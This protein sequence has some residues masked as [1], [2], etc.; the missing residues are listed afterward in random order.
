MK[1]HTK[2]IISLMTVLL[3]VMMLVQSIQYFS[4]MKLIDGLSRSE[5]NMLHR[6]EEQKALSLFLTV[7]RAVEGS[8]IRGEMEKFTHLVQSLS[9]IEGLKAFS[10][11]DA[12]GVMTHSSDPKLIGR[13]LPKDLTDRLYSQSERYQRE[14]D[15]S[16]EIFQPYRVMADCIRCHTT[17]KKDQIG[18]ITHFAFSKEN[19]IQAQ[20]DTVAAMAL[21]QDRFLRT[22]VLAVL[23]LI[24]F[25]A[26]GMY[27]TVRRFVAR[28]LGRVV[29]M[30]RDI[31]QGEGDLTARLELNS[32]DEIGE[33]AGWFNTFVEKL[34][35]VIRQIAEN[36]DALGRA[37]STMS[38]VAGIMARDSGTLSE[39][40]GNL[41]SIAGQ[42][43]HDMGD[44]A[45]SLETLNANIKSIVGAIEETTASVGAISRNAGQS[46][47]IAG[48]AAQ[49]AEQTGQTV[50]KLRTS[51][52]A[53][54]KVIE[55]IVDIAEQTKLLALN[56]TIEAARAGEAGKGFAVVA[57]E[58]KDLAG[59]TSLSTKD[60]RDKVEEIQAISVET[61]ESIDQILKVIGRVNDMAGSIAAAVEQQSS[62]TREIKQSVSQAA[63]AGEEVSISTARAAALCRNMS[64]SIDEV[65]QSSGSTFREAGQVRQASQELAGLAETLRGLLS[66]FRY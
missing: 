12:S 3:V 18:G 37:A 54:G 34:Q 33:L 20:K 22:S 9:D 15:H 63:T 38:D 51:A 39:Q 27:L 4:T 30:L 19:L 40:S 31:A 14:T 41:D 57:G 55:V 45:S 10:L 48:D 52:Q 42:V 8:L 26:L 25:S 2:L 60:I 35:E 64:G 11:Y 17:W 21:I 58:V 16:I 29:S 28:P 32:A 62:F 7:N 1:L 66:S 44:V 47:L 6:G 53:I 56:A 36:I 43:H 65:N 61:A 23:A 50:G 5:I 46:A 59:Q 13:S 24:L 49:R